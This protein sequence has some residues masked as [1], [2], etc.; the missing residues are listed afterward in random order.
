MSYTRNGMLNYKTASP[1]MNVEVIDGI[2]LQADR[3][4]K[5]EVD[6][7]Q[8]G[9]TTRRIRMDDV[10]YVPELSRNLPST[11]KAEE[12]WGKPIVYYSM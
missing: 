3:F 8:P 11:L 5:S 9:S 6:L 10:A 7:D 2:I 1:G 12:K 4:G